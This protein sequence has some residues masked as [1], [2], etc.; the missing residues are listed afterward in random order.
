[1]LIRP[2]WSRCDQKWKASAT[3]DW[4]NSLRWTLS[5]L[6]LNIRCIQLEYA[7]GHVQAYYLYH[8]V[9]P[10]IN[11]F[12]IDIPVIMVGFKYHLEWFLFLILR[13]S[14]TWSAL[15]CIWLN[16]ITSRTW[17]VWCW[18]G[19]PPTHAHVFPYHIMK[20]TL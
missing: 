4:E 14:V 13:C 11:F 20:N 5:C 2:W 6:Q 19:N 17:W 15:S 1:M 18:T 7:T 12:G 16:P 3:L 10:K 8:N 9:T